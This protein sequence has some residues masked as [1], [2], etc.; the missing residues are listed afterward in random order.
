MAGEAGRPRFRFI[1]N[2]CND[3]A[4]MRRFYVEL[5]GLEEAAF[6]D[7]PEFAYLSVEAGG[8]EVMWFRADDELP[9]P[10]EF[11]CQP[12]WEGGTLETTSWAVF[13][14]EER[15][16]TVRQA[17]LSAGVPLFEQEPAWRQDS[18]LAVSA[19]DPMGVTVEVYTVPSSPPATA[20]K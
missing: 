7:T 13:I 4:A 2:V 1:F 20:G 14:P 3:V 6:M 9:A 18:Y 10:T 11:A 16:E 12:G 19:L 15:F 8:F 5:L 17:L